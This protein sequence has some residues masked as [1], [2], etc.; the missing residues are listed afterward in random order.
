[1]AYND[2]KKERLSQKEIADRFSVGYYELQIEELETRISNI[3]SGN[4]DMASKGF[5]YLSADH[6]KTEKDR[7]KRIEY[8]R[9]KINDYKKIITEINEAINTIDHGI[10]VLEQ[11][12]ETSALIGGLSEALRKCFRKYKTVKDERIQIPSSTYD[13]IFVNKL[14]E[15]IV[16]NAKSKYRRLWKKE[17]VD[18]EKK[19]R[20]IKKDIYQK[21]K[22]VQNR[23]MV[24]GK[25]RYTY[26]DDIYN[27]TSLNGAL[28]ENHHSLKGF[29]EGLYH[30][31]SNKYSSWEVES[32]APL[33]VEV[34]KVKRAIEIS[35]G[36]DREFDNYSPIIKSIEY[37]AKEY[38]IYNRFMTFYILKEK[39]DEVVQLSREV[40]CLDLIIDAYDN[41][42]IK[43]S[44]LIVVLKEIYRKQN[45]KLTNLTRKADEMYLRSGIKEYV[46]IESKLRELYHKSGSLKYQASVS[47]EKNGYSD[48]ETRKLT[49]LYLGARSEMLS[50]LLK[51][52]ELNKPEYDIDLTKYDKKGRYVGKE[53][54]QGLIEDDFIPTVVV[55]D[56]ELNNVNK[57]V[58][59]SGNDDFSDPH[60]KVQ[61]NQEEVDQKIQERYASVRTAYYSR[62][63]VEK[64]KN[65]ELGQKTFSEYLEVVA[66]ELEELIDLESRREKKAANVF[67]LY[68]KYLASLENKETAMRFSE[69]ARVR[70]NL[71]ES[72]LPFEYSDEEVKKKLK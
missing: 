5:V 58:S 67:K 23:N 54:H 2:E 9:Q 37:L 21:L 7:Q 13:A 68:V 4:G 41:T 11:A 27:Y 62:Y 48:P 39:L 71:T 24:S 57:E 64:V 40:E 12:A 38:N 43:D 46:E 14:F 66:P 15:G 33:G 51:Y 56:D 22:K 69:F 20:K 10:Y 32:L 53:E 30:D 61:E 31:I 17:Y 59:T 16:P 50:I 3:L 1:M 52:P 63:M 49:D 47:E 34:D 55:T 8:I 65:S 29:A 36:A 42:S 72:D 26:R 25:R 6:L 45:K 19:T 70:Y 44:E 35:D 28:K 18:S 60:P